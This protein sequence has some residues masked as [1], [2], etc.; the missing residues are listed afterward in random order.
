MSGGVITA[1]TLPPNPFSAFLVICSVGI[2]FPVK[3][4]K[5]SKILKDEK[6]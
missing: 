4:Y 3:N 6:N 2:Q 5:P 1:C